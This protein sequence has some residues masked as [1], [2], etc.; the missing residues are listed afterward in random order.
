MER[1]DGDDLSRLRM[2][3]EKVEQLLEERIEEGKELRHLAARDYERAKTEYD[4]W[5]DYNLA[6]LKRL[7]TGKEEVQKY[8]SAGPRYVLPWPRSIAQEVKFLDECFMGGIT[9]LESIKEQLQLFS[10]SVTDEPLPV[11]TDGQLNPAEKARS[12]WVVHGRDQAI[13]D[14]MFQFLRSLDLSPIEWSHALALTGEGS[15]YVGHVLDAAFDAAQAVVVLFTPDDEARL[16]EVFQ[17]DSDEPYESALTPQARPNVL[18]EAGMAFGKYPD[19]TV[20][21]TCGELRPF[22]DVAGRHIVRLD[23]STEKRQELATKLANAG[24]SVDLTGTAWHSVGD[25]QPA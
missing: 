1:S 8:N 5:R 14:S 19:R 20:L 7:F 21:V 6:L 15:P 22:S 24:C 9:A 2:P 13:R 11:D 17:T 25:F 18:F 23:D 10:L 3:P 16:R 12:V 4:K